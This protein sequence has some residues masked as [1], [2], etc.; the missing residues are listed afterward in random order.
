MS[1][2]IKKTPVVGNGQTQSER[3]YK[4]HHS[5]QER[6]ALRAKLDSGDWELING[7]LVR[8]DEWST[9]RDGKQYLRK[10]LQNDRKLVGK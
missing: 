2:S 10:D 3:W 8:W 7:V 1:R 6:A 4:R 5:K 9:G